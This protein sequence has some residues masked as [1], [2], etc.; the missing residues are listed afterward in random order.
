MEERANRWK[1]LGALVA[2]TGLGIFLG[3]FGL[4]RVPRPD[5]KG[6]PDAPAAGGEVAAVPLKQGPS[7]QER[8]DV[9]PALTYPEVF[10]AQQAILGDA[11]F[12]EALKRRGMRSASASVYALQEVARR[13]HPSRRRAVS[14]TQ[15]P[16]QRRPGARDTWYA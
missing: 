11:S 9:Q 16:P 13:G 15:T 12:E 14:S 2:I 6:R 10:A 3:G 7:W 4:L 1:V 5:G 8:D